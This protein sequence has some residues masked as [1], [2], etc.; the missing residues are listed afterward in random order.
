MKNSSVGEMNQLPI[1]CWV[2][3]NTMPD[4]NRRKL[5]KS[6]GAAAGAG[7][8]GLGTAQAKTDDQSTNEDILLTFDPENQKEVRK[9]YRQLSSLPNKRAVEK[10]NRKA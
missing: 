3:C 7:A 2:W 9:A 4:I 8:F 1:M 5:L 10:N 6:I